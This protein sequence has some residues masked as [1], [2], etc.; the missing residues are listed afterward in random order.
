[1]QVG[2]VTPEGFCVYLIPETLR[3]TTMGSKQ[4]GNTVNL[5]IETQTQ[6]PSAKLE[7]LSRG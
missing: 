5:E 6:V 3:V 4:V 2:K 1:M 7:A